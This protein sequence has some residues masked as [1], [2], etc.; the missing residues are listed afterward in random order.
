MSEGLTASVD[1]TTADQDK[2]EHLEPDAWRAIFYSQ[3]RRLEYVNDLPPSWIGYPEVEEVLKQIKDIY[4]QNKYLVWPRR[5]VSSN[6]AI[7]WWSGSWTDLADRC[8]IS[9]LL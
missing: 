6:P 4:D 8:R 9:S 1:A 3:E 7:A 5:W 2:P